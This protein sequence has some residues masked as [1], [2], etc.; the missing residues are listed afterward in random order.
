[1]KNNVETVVAAKDAELNALKARVLTMENAMLA[2]FGP[3][4]IVTKMANNF[5]SPDGIIATM[6]HQ[7]DAIQRK[8]CPPTVPLLPES[9]SWELHGFTFPLRS[10]VDMKLLDI[11]ITSGGNPLL[12]PDLVSHS[13]LLT[14]RVLQFN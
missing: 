10:I 9:T 4:G 1:M 12:A 2:A 3:D 11:E 8:V 5:N 6:A 14:E 7:L 13:H